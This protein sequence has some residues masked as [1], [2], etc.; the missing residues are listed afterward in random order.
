MPVNL[1]AQPSQVRYV[2]E[3][4]ESR[5]IFATPEWAAKLR[6]GIVAEKAAPT[7]GEIDSAAPVIA[8]EP[9]C[10]T[11]VETYAPRS[12]DLALLMYTSGTTG[13][14][15]S[16]MLTHG[17]L[18]ANAH[19]ISREHAL[20]AG[21]RFAAVLPLYHISAFTVTMVA[22]LAHGGSLALAPRFS[23]TRFWPLVVDR[24]CTWINV[25]PTIISYLLDGDA[26]NL[27]A[28]EAV[29]TCRS[30]SAALP[31][32]HHRA[33][34]ARFGIG[35][36]ETIGLTETV[37]LAFRSPL[38]PEQRRIGLVVRASGCAAR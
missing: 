10:E 38:D 19:A 18:A 37:A 24:R 7:I 22:P 5:L 16:V 31:P 9:E 1:L 36:I 14:P 2:L 15:K 23:A 17:N 12:E 35:I 34:E 33:F 13:K 20:G 4:A 27:A 32:E 28:I 11:R 25:V 8:A 21:D 6:Q 3:H 30:A 29:R 26:P